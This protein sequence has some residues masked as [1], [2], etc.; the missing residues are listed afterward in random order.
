MKKR[1]AL[2]LALLLL[3]LPA[4]L[5]AGLEY[6]TDTLQDGSLVFYFD[7]LSLT[8]PSGWADA[9]LAIPTDSGLSFYQRESYERYEAEGIPGGGFLFSL[10][11][12]VNGSFSELPAFKYLGF[13]EKSAMNYFLVL[14]TDYPA[15]FEDSVRAEYDAMHAQID[16]IARSVV[17]YGE[18]TAPAPQ[19]Q[20]A[21]QGQDA[22]ADD[23]GASLAQARYHFEHNAL[24]RYFYEDPAN[25]IGVLSERGVYALWDAFARENGVSSPYAESDYRVNRHDLDD[26]TEMLQIELPRP[27]ANTLC[28]RIYM[29][30]NATTGAAGYYTVEYDNLLGETAFLC[31]WSSAHEHINY[32]GAAVLTRD[33]AD[34]EAALAEELARVAALAGA[35]VAPGPEA[36][37]PGA[38]DDDLVPVECPQLGFSTRIDPALSWEYE[39]GSGIYIYTEHEGSIPYALI[40]HTG[41]T[42]L[43]PLEFIREQFTP[44]MQQQYGEDL[45]AINEL[46]IYEIGGKQLPAGLYT[47]RLQGHLVDMLRL[48]DI[49]ESGTMIYTAKYLET[50]GEAT[51][52]ALDTAIRNLTV[53]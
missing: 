35:S 26:G 39:E 4:A 48:Y 29:A 38:P 49:S 50:E 18:E 36:P 14:P 34:Y 3:A 33:S 8:L 23:D 25:M 52:K 19:D 37:G 51:L 17:V 1:I 47:Y 15:Y 24:P 45:V 6:T 42:I 10:G 16:D 22:P 21:P 53:E 31:G 7:D 12:S 40:Y 27:D 44:H 13:S 41:D 11:A 9:V 43:E 20:S 28:Y 2:L 32:G 46:E 5:A 30:Y